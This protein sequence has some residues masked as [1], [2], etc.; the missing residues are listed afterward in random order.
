[1]FLSAYNFFPFSF[2]YSYVSFVFLFS[3]SL[4]VVFAVTPFPSVYVLSERNHYPSAFL[5]RVWDSLLFPPLMFVSV[6]PPSFLSLVRLGYSFRSHSFPFSLSYCL[7]SSFYPSSSCF[8]LSP[9]LLFLPFFPF[10]LSL[11]IVF[12]VTPFPSVHIIV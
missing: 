3:F 10:S 1:M 5:L 2:R 7:C 12:A 9:L 11:C 8:L 4:S 6:P